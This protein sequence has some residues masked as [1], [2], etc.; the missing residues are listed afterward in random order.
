MEHDADAGAGAASQQTPMPTGQQLQT[1]GN[2]LPLAT[3]ST[4]DGVAVCAESDSVRQDTL[5][6]PAC[7]EAAQRE[8]HLF[9]MGCRN[10]CA[11]AAARSPQFAAA[12][13]AG[14]LDHQYRRLL[15]QFGL[16]HDQVKAAAALDKAS[17]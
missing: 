11:R 2:G 15:Q 3:A 17:T 1:G 6:C 5:Q 9:Q 13:K 4:S 8:S 10:C 16:T 7:A 14:V 12:R